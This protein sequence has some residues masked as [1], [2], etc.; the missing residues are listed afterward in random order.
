M[1]CRRGCIPAT[2]EMHCDARDIVQVH[3]TQS[4]VH[5]AQSLVHATQSLVHATQSLTAC[6]T[7]APEHTPE[8]TPEHIPRVCSE[9]RRITTTGTPL[10]I[11]SRTTNPKVSES[12]GCRAND[13]TNLSHHHRT[14][15]TESIGDGGA[16]HSQTMRA[17]DASTWVRGRVTRHHEDISGRKSAGKLDTAHQSCKDRVGPRKM[18]LGAGIGAAFGVGSLGLGCEIRPQ[19]KPR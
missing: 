9:P 14:R 19:Q 4:Q 6:R 18:F 3:A 2:S 5:A 17:T 7:H 10:A 16:P 11:D 12:E 8:H 15:Q 1:G 13:A